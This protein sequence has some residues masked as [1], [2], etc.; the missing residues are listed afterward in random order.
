MSIVK[1]QAATLILR[2]ER[3]VVTMP[4]WYIT[5]H[6]DVPLMTDCVY[7]IVS[8]AR[9]PP[10]STAPQALLPNGQCYNA[11]RFSCVAS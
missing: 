8:T 9:G 11:D 7:E 5:W 10:V 3:P 6:I 4:E 2:T 1:P